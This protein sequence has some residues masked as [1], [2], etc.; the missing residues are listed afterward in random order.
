[1]A[2]TVHLQSMAHTG[3]TNTIKDNETDHMDAQSLRDNRYV[4]PQGLETRFQDD[5]NGHIMSAYAGSLCE[6]ERT[7]P[8]TKSLPYSVMPKRV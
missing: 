7:A 4:V 2:D 1:M 3:H 6:S 5:D 8:G